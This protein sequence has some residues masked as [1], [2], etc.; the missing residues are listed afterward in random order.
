MKDVTNEQI[1][2]L[3]E[4]HSSIHVIRYLAKVKDIS[5]GEAKKIVDELKEK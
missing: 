4:L 5:L 3:L 2:E 1:K